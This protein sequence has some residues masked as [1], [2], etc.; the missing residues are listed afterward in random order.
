M[1][2]LP[3]FLLAS[4]AAL[5]CLGG[6]A[7]VD[8][9]GAASVVLEPS[10]LV[11]GVI[12]QGGRGYGDGSLASGIAG[13]SGL[14]V[15]PLA[16]EAAASQV[17]VIVRLTTK[18]SLVETFSARTRKPL[19]SGRVSFWSGYPSLYRSVGSHLLAEFSPSK[20]LYQRLVAEKAGGKAGESAVGAAPPTAP[21]AASFSS[22]IESPRYRLAE[23]DKDFAVVVGIED[24]SDLPKAVYAERDAEAFAAHARALGVPERNL[25]VL[26]GSKAG[27]AALEKYLEQWLPRLVGPESRV[28]F[29]FSGH[30]A[31][32][33]KT[34]QAYLVPWDG[35]ANF[36]ET[37]AYPVRRLYERL[38]ALKAK[39]VLVAMDSCFS[40]AGGRSVLATGAR[41]LVT[42]VE[43][44][45][46]EGSLTVLSASGARE[47]S[48]SLPDRGHGA[49]TYFLLKGLNGDAKDFTAS[50]LLDYLTPRVQDEARRLNRDQT[51]QL[52]GDGALSFR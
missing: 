8:T 51:P 34:G 38:N 42:F 6:C 12:W 43:T 23:R 26:R 29:F 4:A 18:T 41:P 5:S 22:D 17:D 20:E 36:L 31:P 27:R 39:S 49:F 30:G 32:D 52:Q 2:S 48:G 7:A 44:G 33:V 11:F 47:I 25:V 46:V 3:V 14:K 45:A 37:T 24:Y 19:T 50:G 28:Y 35:D 15:V 40:G 10:A 1:R 16:S 9:T 13:K 21:A